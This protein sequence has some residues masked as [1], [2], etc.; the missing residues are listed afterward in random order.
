MVVA[1]VLLI[2]LFLVALLG[3]I[4]AVTYWRNGNFKRS[5]VQFCLAIPILFLTI[6][7]VRAVPFLEV[8]MAQGA[9]RTADP[10]LCAVMMRKAYRLV[11]PT[12]AN[13]EVGSFDPLLRCAVQTVVNDGQ[14]AD[15]PPLDAD[16]CWPLSGKPNVLLNCYRMSFLEF[17]KNGELINAQQ[18]QQLVGLLAEWRSKHPGAPVYAIFYVH[19]WRHD[20]RLG[21][22]DV[23]RARVIASYA[24]GNLQERCRV[25]GR[26]C[27]TLVLGIY[28]S[29][30]AAI[31]LVDG[32]EDVFAV[33]N[34]LTFAGRKLVS[35]AIGQAVMKE[36][37]QVSEQIRATS[38]NTR[39]LMLG[40]SLGGDLLLTGA[41]GLLKSGL[42]QS[43]AIFDGRIEGRLEDQRLG[44]PADL[45]VLL[46]PAAPASKWENISLMSA[47]YF[48]AKDRPCPEGI[49][50]IWPQ[51]MPP[52]LIYLASRCRSD[53]NPQAAPTMTSNERD[54]LGVSKDGTYP[55]DEVVG[56][57]FPISQKLLEWTNEPLEYKGV[58]HL[59]DTASEQ[60]KAALYRQNGLFL[61]VNWQK[62]QRVYPTTYENARNY[63]RSR[64]F[65]EPSWLYCA[66]TRGTDFGR[67]CG[68]QNSKVTNSWRAWDA[69]KGGR[70]E[71]T[72]SRFAETGAP[73]QSNVQ[74]GYPSARGRRFGV[75]PQNSDPIWGVEAHGTAI[76]GH[77]LVAS[78]PLTCSYTKM[79]FD[80]V[81]T[82]PASATSGP[83][84]FIDNGTNLIDYQR[85]VAMFSR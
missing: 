32:E 84:R 71:K 1:A 76:T 47:N 30:P 62:G 49:C 78:S 28:V 10:A 38:P 39:V 21:D 52:R 9:T 53:I 26:Q 14:P 7:S 31:G 80:D 54:S 8:I 69:G 85:M 24:A 2:A 19:G 15:A 6:N 3:F 67:R 82:P 5:T 70:V 44:L 65:V 37:T 46:N 25:S 56:G 59:L 50:R 81:S 11:S 43:A 12:L 77:G 23:R 22:P 51:T 13:E 55:C 74:F 60:E 18:K 75:M 34:G 40:H 63:S 20:A 58:G 48:Q 17:N 29:W 66:R 83:N 4:K 73:G 16:R 33:I 27:N 68:N 36:L 45:T 72:L 61:E 42:A 35:E 41:S 57:I 79:L 64:C